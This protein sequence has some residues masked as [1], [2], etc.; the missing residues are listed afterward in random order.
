M[1]V[2]YKVNDR[3]TIDVDVKDMK[4]AFDFLAYADSIFRV[5]ECGNCGSKDLKLDTRN[6]KGYIY[7]SILCNECKHTLKVSEQKPEKGGKMY[8]NREWEEPF[9]GGSEDGDGDNGSRRRSNREDSDHDEE[10]EDSDH[11]E[12]R[13]YAAADDIS[14]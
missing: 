10:R 5:S 14:F 7:R 2:D 4:Q 11:D 13:R 9:Y 6:P 3:C 8:L 1:K 12:K